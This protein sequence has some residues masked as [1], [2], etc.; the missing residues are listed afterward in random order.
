MLIPTSPAPA[1][2]IIWLIAV[3]GCLLL[4][5]CDMLIASSTLYA[6][7][8]MG[9]WPVYVTSFYL[10]DSIIKYSIDFLAIS[11]L[12]KKIHSIEML[13]YMIYLEMGIN[14]FC[15]NNIFHLF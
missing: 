14:F 5:A 6:L 1:S 7:R 11:S 15:N 13:N 8:D 10:K 2:H 4:L 9:M 12:I 3:F